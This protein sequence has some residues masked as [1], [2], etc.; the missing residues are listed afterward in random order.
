MRALLTLGAVAGLL[1][2]ATGCIGEWPNPGLDEARVGFVYVGPI[3]DHGWTLTHEVG[4]QELNANLP[5][6]TSRFEPSVLPSDAADVMERFIDE[7]DNVIVTTS[8]DYVTATQ[9]V[10]ANHPEV[11]LLSCSGFVSGPNLGS[12]FGRMYQPKYL[13]GLVAGSM[14]CT[15]RIGYVAPVNVPEVVRHINAFALGV[16]EVNP[17]AVVYVAWV[18]NW[19]DLEIEPLAAQ[20]LVD[21]GADI[22]VGS[23]DTSIPLE[24]VSGQTVTCDPGTGPVDVPVYSIGYDNPD[25]CDAAPTECLTSA[26]WN[27]G[28]MYTALVTEMLDGTWAPQNDLWEPMQVTPEESTVHLSEINPVVPADVRFLVEE[29]TLEVTAPDNQM[30][31]FVGPIRDTRG[32]ERVAAGDAL[33]DDDLLEMC[34]LVEGVRDAAEPDEVEARVPAG[35]GGVE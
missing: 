18:G 6:V 25:A 10:A 2:T 13:S 7:G 14:T 16:R 19:F 17:D 21:L 33:T 12:Y 22:V 9:S 24:T 30:L 4:R 34:W 15:D 23:T 8:F 5:E 11:N 35:C 28:P 20:S 26:Y 29:R 32:T 1:A 27:W 3:G 31:P